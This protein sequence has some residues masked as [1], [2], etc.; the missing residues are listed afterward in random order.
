MHSSV[1]LS[2]SIILSLA[3][4]MGVFLPGMALT[5]PMRLS[6]ANTQSN[7]PPVKPKEVGVINFFAGV[8]QRSLR[9]LISAVTELRVA[10]AEEILINFNSYGG[11]S[12]AGLAAYNYLKSLPIP[13]RTHNLGF[14]AS[15]SVKIFCA[16]SI[17]TAAPQSHFL[18]H[19][20][21]LTLGPSLTPPEVLGALNASRNRGNFTTE[22]LAD[23]M[24]QSRNRVTDMLRDEAVFNAKEARQFGLIQ[25]ILTNQPV[26]LSVKNQVLIRDE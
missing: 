10:G 14:T 18:I 25:Q 23:C 17:R 5:P 21:T 6:Q 3:V 2:K 26:P 20:G 15:A 16:G 7:T 9:S 22:I 1:R 19:Y 8:N 11:D 24:G 12:D 4:T 13:I